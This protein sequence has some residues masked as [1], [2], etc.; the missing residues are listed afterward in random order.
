MIHHGDSKY[1]TVFPVDIA[2]SISDR[3]L[4][5]IYPPTLTTNISSAKS[6]FLK[7]MSSSISLVPSVQTSLSPEW[8]KR[9]TLMT[10]LPSSVRRFWASRKASLKR[11]LPQRVMIG[12][13]HLIDNVDGS[14]ISVSLTQDQYVFQI[15]LCGL[16]TCFM[17]HHLIRKTQKQLLRMPEDQ[18]QYTDPC[19]R[20]RPS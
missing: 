18:I 15:I 7:C 5:P 12:I 19:D 3:V 2:Y 13:I 20:T 16:M 9:P 17:S 4:D 6:I 14:Y 8:P 1:L 11:V 10:I